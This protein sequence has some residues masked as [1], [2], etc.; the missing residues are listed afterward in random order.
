MN[1][2]WD[3]WN[4][5]WKEEEEE[6]EG[7]DAAIEIPVWCLRGLFTTIPD[8]VGGTLPAS[9]LVIFHHMQQPPLDC[10]FLVAGQ[11]WS[12]DRARIPMAT[13]GPL[14]IISYHLIIRL[15]FRSAISRGAAECIHGWVV[16][17]F[18][19]YAYE[20][21]SVKYKTKYSPVQSSIG[22]NMI[23]TL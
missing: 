23:Y 1:G 8:W 15:W 2:M 10:L 9:C 13:H 19:I 14:R 4:G 16:R 20:V 5:R 22:E 18:V 7:D 11:R 21:R 17:G 3:D 6:E 12:D